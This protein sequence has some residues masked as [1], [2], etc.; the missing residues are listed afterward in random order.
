MSVMV[1]KVHIK[2]FNNFFHD[3]SIFMNCYVFKFWKENQL[4]F[5]RTPIQPIVHKWRDK[6]FTP[7]FAR[8]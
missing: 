4:K 2:H 1:S 3:L 7:I 8:A 6:C 5:A